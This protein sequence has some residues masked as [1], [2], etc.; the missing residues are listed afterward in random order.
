MK[1]HFLFILGFFY[2][3]TGHA[4]DLTLLPEGPNNLNYRIAYQF[5]YDITDFLHQII[6]RQNEVLT[7]LLGNNPDPNKLLALIEQAKTGDIKI[8]EAL[9]YLFFEKWFGENILTGSSKN[10]YFKNIP[11]DKSIQQALYSLFWGGS[12]RTY[13]SFFIDSLK[14]RFMIG[15]T[16]EPLKNKQLSVEFI[17][18]LNQSKGRGFKSFDYLWA[19]Y[20]L[21]G[22][23]SDHKYSSSF[24]LKKEPIAK[25]IIRTLALENYIPAI[26]LKSFLELKTGNF[27]QESLKQ[28]SLSLQKIYNSEKKNY[29]INVTVTN[30]LAILHHYYLGN[31]KLAQK[32]LTEAIYT[33][34]V[35]IFKPALL[36]SYLSTGDYPSAL[37]MAQE[38]MLD[39][40]NHPIDYIMRVSRFISSAFYQGLGQLQQNPFEA[41]V[42]L[43]ISESIG[44]RE[45]RKRLENQQQIQEKE[46]REDTLIQKLNQILPTNTI[47][48]EELQNWP[49]NKDQAHK[50]MKQVKTSPEKLIYEDMFFNRLEIEQLEQKEKSMLKASTNGRDIEQFIQEYRKEISKAQNDYTNGLTKNTIKEA[51]EKAKAYMELIVFGCQQVFH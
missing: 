16:A 35:K 47:T 46:K 28:I 49:K 24:F 40:K 20:M 7:Q 30:L 25:E 12:K 2:Y 44:L 10:D 11:W 4:I 14:A 27:S 9:T 45:K 3:G 34:Q 8:R 43:E 21:D 42:W 41:L 15:S 33:N 6:T 36:D 51:K 39:Y 19:F 29:D 31:N 22:L 38:I 48:K 18:L 17:V 26:Y 50:V 32:F 23:Y 13:E 1:K 5:K 37:K